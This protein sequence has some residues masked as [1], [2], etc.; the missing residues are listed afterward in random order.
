MEIT[1]SF[2]TS[3]A[4]RNAEYEISVSG[5]SHIDDLEKVKQVI[6]ALQAA[7]AQNCEKEELK[8]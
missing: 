4:M 3:T 1:I 6:N 5:I 7:T 8:N 2:D